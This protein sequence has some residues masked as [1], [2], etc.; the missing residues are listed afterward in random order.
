MPDSSSHDALY[1]EGMEFIEAGKFDQALANFQLVMARDPAHL[2]AR[3][4]AGVCLLALERYGESAEALE[5]AIELGADDAVFFFLLAEV[6]NQLEDYARAAEALEQGI[7]HSPEAIPEVFVNLGSLYY[8]MERYLE[9]VA[10]LKQAL[11]LKPGDADAWFNLGTTYTA[12]KQFPEAVAAYEQVVQQHPDDAET[13]R[14][15]GWACLYAERNPEALAA[16]QRSLQLEPE[17]AD[18]HYALGVAFAVQGDADAAQRQ[19]EILSDLDP[20]LAEAL[21]VVISA[22]EDGEES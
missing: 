15:L 22:G 10:A 16:L 5:K 1:R 11:A 2:N 19:I 9:S 14:R 3:L 12:M 4:Q 8:E 6:Y 7:Q 21:R 20:G 18:S 17:K 13:Y